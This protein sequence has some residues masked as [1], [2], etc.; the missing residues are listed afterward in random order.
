[1]LSDDTMYFTQNGLTEKASALLH[2]FTEIATS[3]TFKGMPLILDKVC[4]LQPDVQQ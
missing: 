3:F 4:N 2:H 1:M